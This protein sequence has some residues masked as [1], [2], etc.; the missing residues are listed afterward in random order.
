MVT[1]VAFGGFL[2]NSLHTLVK[3]NMSVQI[4]IYICMMITVYDEN[5]ITADV[6]DFMRQGSI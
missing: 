3:P 4:Y 5:R 2:V 1:Q 6:E